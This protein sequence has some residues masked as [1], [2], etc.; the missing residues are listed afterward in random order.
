[1]DL[2]HRPADQRGC[3]VV[4][5]YEYNM[6][7]LTWQVA[8]VVR[9][10]RAALPVVGRAGTVAEAWWR[11]LTEFPARPEA[12]LTLQAGVRPSGL[13]VFCLELARLA[14][15]LALQAH[16]GNGVVVGRLPA[17]ATAAEAEQCVTQAR[18]LAAKAQGH[19]VVLRC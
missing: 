17:D 15:R 8:Q 6:E 19:V 11:G 12:A 4:V 10:T 3:A 16:A 14:P 13:V 2:A 1:R 9:E 5:G 18:Q 7:A